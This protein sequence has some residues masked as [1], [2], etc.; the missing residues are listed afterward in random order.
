MAFLVGADGVVY[1]KNLGKKTESVA[2][3]IKEYDPGS[4]GRS[5]GGAAGSCWLKAKQ[6][7]RVSLSCW[8]PNGTKSKHRLPGDVLTNVV[9]NSLTGVRFTLVENS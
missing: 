9:S 1:E 8:T 2:K 6:V 5:G 3:A 7:K 4:A